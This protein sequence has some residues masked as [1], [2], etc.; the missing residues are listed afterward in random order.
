VE[1]SIT[2][3]GMFGLTWPRW[4]V[5]T[6]AIERLGFAGCYRSD[7]FTRGSPPDVDALEMIVSL[8][9]LASHSKRVRMGPLVSPVSFRDPI[10]LARQA[11]AIDDLSGGRM[12]LG[13]GAGWMVSEHEMFGYALGDLKTRMDRLEEGL[14]VITRLIRSPEPVTFEGRF[15]TLREAHLLPR[16][17]RP[18]PVM[19]GGKGPLRSMPM[20]ARFADIWNC[21]PVPV[22]VYSERSGLLD[23]LLVKQGRRPADVKRTVMLHVHVWRDGADR[24]RRLDLARQN[25]PVLAGMSDEDTLSHLRDK[26]GAIVGTPDEVV[27]RIRAYAEAGAQE[28][29]LQWFTLGDVDGLETLAE[30]VMPSV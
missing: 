30:L 11:M 23:Q 25:L 10:M 13:V 8:T 22:A 28:A 16:P 6:G 21:T 27:P 9:H 19:V 5:L 26:M 24:A 3:E 29:M 20:V 2:I 12:V 1:L 15:Y 14:E 17:A 18:T 4:E 7:H